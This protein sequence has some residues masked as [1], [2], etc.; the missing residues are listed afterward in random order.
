MMGLTNAMMVAPE[1]AANA[2][3]EAHAF[4]FNFNKAERNL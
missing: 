1:L 4:R 2:K 3:G